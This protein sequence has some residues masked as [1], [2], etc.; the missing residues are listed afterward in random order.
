M[1]VIFEK[2]Y[3][4]SNTNTLLSG[5]PV[6]KTGLR[7][8][9]YA[10]LVGPEATDRPML[11]LLSNDQEINLHVEEISRAYTDGV[12][13]NVGEAFQVFQTSATNNTSI[14]FTVHEGAGKIAAQVFHLVYQPNVTYE[15][16]V[17]EDQNSIQVPI[18]PQVTLLN[19]DVTGLTTN[20]FRRDLLV[21]NNAGQV[22]VLQGQVQ[23][24]LPGE[25]SQIDAP[26]DTIALYSIL[27]QKVTGVVQTPTISAVFDTV[28]IDGVDLIQRFANLFGNGIFIGEPIT[29]TDPTKKEFFPQVLGGNQ[30]IAAAGSALIHG[31]LV[32][33]GSAGNRIS[34]SRA[35]FQVGTDVVPGP[36]Q[37]QNPN[38]WE[39]VDFTSA[40]VGAAGV[41]NG[42]T[43]FLKF[44]NLGKTGFMDAS[45]VIYT[46]SPV[47]E[48][49]YSVQRPFDTNI[50]NTPTTEEYSIDL[51]TG[52]IKREKTTAPLRI[53]IK[54]TFYRN[55]RY[56]PYF[57]EF[58]TLNSIQS[59]DSFPEIPAEFSATQ[60]PAN[61]IGLKS[62]LFAATDTTLQPSN[63]GHDFRVY[64]NFVL[65]NGQITN[66]SIKD[67]TITGAK[68]AS[69]AID[70]SDLIANQVIIQRHLS[71]E[72]QDSLSSSHVYARHSLAFPYTGFTNIYSFAD[73]SN[74]NGDVLTKRLTDIAGDNLIYTDAETQNPADRPVVFK[75]V[76]KSFVSTEVS[77]DPVNTTA[78]LT[79]NASD[80]GNITVPNSQI[81]LDA[82]SISFQDFGFSQVGNALVQVY[83]HL[84][85]AVLA[86]KQVPLATIR[87]A[88][89]GKTS[90]FY[91]FVLDAPVTITLGRPFQIRISKTISTDTLFVHT[92][93]D[94]A[95]KNNDIS[96]R[97]FYL[98]ATGKYGLIGGRVQGYNIY[99][100]FG[101]ITIP[102]QNRVA[103]G[104]P[105]S[106]IPYAA[107]IPSIGTV[108]VFTDVDS[109]VS[110]YVAVDV[111]RGIFEFSSGFE[112]TTAK[113]YTDHNINQG[114]A[115]LSSERIHRP[116]GSTIESS[117]R[118]LEDE[119]GSVQA[120][121]RNHH[122][123]LYSL[124]GGKFRFSSQD[125]NLV[126]LGG[127][128]LKLQDGNLLNP[129]HVI[130]NQYLVPEGRESSR[131][132]LD[133]FNDTDHIEFTARFNNI[134]IFAINFAL[135]GTDYDAV[136]I[137][138]IDGAF[139]P[140][141][142]VNPPIASATLAKS[143]IKS[144]F[145][146]F[147][148]KANLSV[149]SKY[150][151]YIKVINFLGGLGV[152]PTMKVD[153]EN[154]NIEYQEYF[155]PQPGKYGTLP[156]YTIY[157][158]FGDLNLGSESRGSDIDVSQLN[159]LDADGAQVQPFFDD[160]DIDPTLANTTFPIFSPTKPSTTGMV[161]FDIYFKQVPDAGADGF[162][163]VFRLML[164]DSKNNPVRPANALP[165]QDFLDVRIPKTT[166]FYEIPFIASLIFGE[167][168]HMHIWGNGFDLYL[169]VGTHPT[170]GQKAFRFVAGDRF[171]PFA[172]DLSGDKFDTFEI[173]SRK[174]VA[175]DVTAGRIKF[176]PDDITEGNFYFAD[177]NLFTKTSQL[178]SDTIVRPNGET[179]ENAFLNTV[180]V[181]DAVPTRVDIDVYKFNP[182]TIKMVDELG[183]QLNRS[184]AELT[185]SY[186]RISIQDTNI[187]GAASQL[188]SIEDDN[189]YTFFIDHYESAS[190]PSIILNYD[191]V[192]K[193]S[194]NTILK[195]YKQGQS[196]AIKQAY[197][198][199][200][201]LVQ[202][203]NTIILE[204]TS[205]TPWNFMAD[206]NV[207]YVFKYTA[208][209]I[210]VGTA[211]KLAKNNNNIIT[212]TINIKPSNDGLYGTFN[213][214]TI[215]DG[216]GDVYR[217]NF[218]RDDKSVPVVALNTDSGL[219]N[220]KIAKGTT[221]G[222][223]VW[224]ENS[225]IRASRFDMATGAIIDTTKLSIAGTSGNAAISPDVAVSDD[226]AFTT[227]VQSGQ[228]YG[229]RL[230]INSAT[231]MAIDAIPYQVSVGASGVASPAVAAGR[232]RVVY[233]WEDTRDTPSGTINLVNNDTNI[234][235]F[236][237]NNATATAQ[238]VPGSN[239]NGG[240][241]R[242]NNSALATAKFKKPDV[243]VFHD[244]AVFTY[245]TDINNPAVS[246]DIYLAVY[247]LK[248]GNLL[249]SDI[250]VDKAPAVTTS[251]VQFDSNSAKISTY[252][253]E[254]AIAWLDNRNGNYQV[255]GKVYDSNSLTFNQSD[256]LLA[257]NSGV[258]QHNIDTS[259]KILVVSFRSGLNGF[260]KRLDFGSMTDHD[261]EAWDMNF[262]SVLSNK[263][264][265]VCAV[266]YGK[267]I[268]SFAIDT[269]GTAVIRS[270][271]NGVNI[272]PIAVDL[273]DQTRQIPAG[274]VGIDVT[275]N[276]FKFADG[277][278]I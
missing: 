223:A 276:I 106:Y 28:R 270:R 242:V 176:H 81:A 157:D 173:V 101:D 51:T 262:N 215:K 212:T 203:F 130:D 136:Q 159:F 123:K 49:G 40:S 29:E 66:I 27:F 33:Y 188:T 254:H 69:G 31:K 99:D 21:L 180:P 24:F 36:I 248:S 119:L 89:L 197:I 48:G 63:F 34:L 210:G 37:G 231:P 71:T 177:F 228:V 120:N 144:D 191:T 272:E 206:P 166:G 189:T 201:D 172:A 96:F 111:T 179:I 93:S 18:P 92:A 153:V 237:F 264:N 14:Q 266:S 54:Y 265:E 152:R 129:I 77:T 183:R 94:G 83:D 198:R 102:N 7:L 35:T 68:L 79:I 277:E 109:A 150:H 155:I 232:D 274:Y 19:I 230:F 207:Q 122:E 15:D 76:F 58:G 269:S 236:S 241:F 97:A 211:P 30:I 267:I 251:S 224:Q 167:S 149:G 86:T 174:L 12:F 240:V 74:P 168:Y 182:R 16:Q 124:G 218:A 194:Y 17:D 5:V 2:T 199:S 82:V 44:D 200:K 115:D 85:N 127:V 143:A 26:A 156:G 103:L 164:H 234:F 221:R 78:T 186:E 181:R 41:G 247:D 238:F 147:V 125:R 116:G 60:L 245:Q 145:N 108:T 90:Q 261:S 13:P 107:D 163:G 171:I 239:A 70:N 105:E 72:L 258:L 95:G 154:G 73:N 148:L 32:V 11:S 253:N 59:A 8:I 162:N 263:I 10:D 56:L 46:A 9:D 202:G 137:V 128:N 55:R 220:L 135:A 273:S 64:M 84:G 100:D 146:F 151:I 104:K 184:D 208:D 233:T 160:N 88:L 195:V 22:L 139:V 246:N 229:R 216:Q 193:S 134:A 222:V 235:A 205:G 178:Q 257:D 25:Y 117:L 190:I 278:E 118:V 217:Y 268:N 170:T 52:T 225:S 196:T 65:E 275:N 53:F 132:I 80:I 38:G 131:P 133:N 3:G 126:D 187:A 20:S 169:Y 23:S 142:Y 47:G 249:R 256:V 259:E 50:F 209:V 214:V 140:G 213:G 260:V 175:V 43:Q 271:L 192:T 165:G 87:N 1:A 227:W 91:K 138:L 45:I 121:V 161:R 255:F 112:P 98:P 114:F 62:I 75:N 243:S 67:G 57:D 244:R 42:N 39:L 252:R 226:V 204:D 113:I 110:N 6:A 4:L 61:T 158:Q 219:V 141:D 185:K 250:R